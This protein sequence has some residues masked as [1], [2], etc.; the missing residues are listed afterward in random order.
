MNRPFDGPAAIAALAA[1]RPAAVALAEIV[2]LAVTVERTLLREARLSLPGAGPETE[3]DLY[4]SDLVLDHN[5]ARL[6]LRPEAAHHLRLRLAA[7]PARLEQAWQLVSARHEHISATARTEELLQWH[8]LRGDT[9]AVRELL[10][11]CVSTVV[12]AG[13]PGFAAWAIDA[14][15]RMDPTVRELEE[16]RMLG[17]GAAMRTGGQRDQLATLADDRLGEWLDWLAPEAM[18]RTEL[19][20]TL[21]EG[22]IEFGPASEARYGQRIS[23]PARFP[24]VIEVR[25]NGGQTHPLALRANAPTLVETGS[26]NLTITAEDGT[27][28]RVR[29]PTQRFVQQRR[30]PRVHLTYETEMFGKIRPVEL[31]FV[32]GVIAD[33]GGHRMP[34]R[35]RLAMREFVE[36]DYANL[37]A[38]MSRIRPF[39]NLMVRDVITDVSVSECRLSFATMADFQPDKIME[40]V[41]EIKSLYSARQCLTDLLAFMDGKDGAQSLMRDVFAKDDYIFALS[42]MT[43]G[44]FG[45]R[46][47]SERRLAREQYLKGD[48][49]GA[50]ATMEGFPR[51]SPETQLASDQAFLARLLALQEEGLG[52]VSGQTGGQS[53]GT[54]PDPHVRKRSRRQSFKRQ[55]KPLPAQIVEV[56]SERVKVAFAPRDQERQDRIEIAIAEVCAILADYPD[57]NDGDAFSTI[58]AAIS[59]LDDYIGRQINQIMTHPDFRRL[60]S[61]WRGLEFLL[62]RSATGPN[63]KIKVL[64]IARYELSAASRCRAPLAPDGTRGELFRHIYEA[65]F[66]QRGGEPFTAIVCDF[67]FGDGKDD[68]DILEQLGT[69]GKYARTAFIAAAAPAALELNSWDNLADPRDLDPDRLTLSGSRNY[70]EWFRNTDAARHIVLTLPGIV[71]RPQ[72]SDRDNPVE[73]FSFNENSPPVLINAAWGLGH[74]IARACADYGWPVRIKGAESGGII[75]NLPEALFEGEVQPRNVEVMVTDRREWALSQLGLTPVLGIK[76]ADRTCFVSAQTLYRSVDDASPISSP[77]GS[78]LHYEL[79][80]ARFAHHLMCMHRDRLVSKT[81]TA[82]LQADF[83]D[84]VQTWVSTD[85]TM[86]DETR[87]RFPLREARVDVGTADPLTD[88]AEVRLAIDPAYQ[89]YG[90]PSLIEGHFWVPLAS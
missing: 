62:S 39:L 67:A 42:T 23:L 12:D 50:I 32:I 79:A 33:L 70:T 61:T 83:T 88:Y 10:R 4:F 14:I 87:A 74:C 78:R 89:L 15:G 5:P 26:D 8:A 60:E 9:P 76:D 47:D 30:K 22:G 20:V 77:M 45:R 6:V 25:E 17:I 11:A 29:A 44:R 34:G 2:S 36:V 84:W 75:D 65:V 59:V 31:P 19:G 82:T 54:K 90:A 3:A 52:E 28:M 13:R 49:S 55:Q 46:Y 37:D 63:L 80:H 24:Q 7:D 66:G 40:Q 85:E 53:R 41:P 18:D 27:R 81:D 43:V 16:Y 64:D 35:T 73:A 57:L 58:D 56:I 68:L 21:V 38:Q 72:W 69:I 71:G 86:S 51:G 48:I 1:T